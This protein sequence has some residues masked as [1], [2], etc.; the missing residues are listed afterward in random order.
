MYDFI[1]DISLRPK[2]FSRYT[3]KELWTQPHHVIFLRAPPERANG[4]IAGVRRDV[5]HQSA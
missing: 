4:A 5:S 3:A 2:P 1:Y